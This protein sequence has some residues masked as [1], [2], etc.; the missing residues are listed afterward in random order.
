MFL[1]RIASVILTGCLACDLDRS[2]LVATVKLQAT[3]Q[4]PIHW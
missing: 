3:I 4:F 2:I 1:S